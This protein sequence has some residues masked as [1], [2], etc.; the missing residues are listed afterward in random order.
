MPAT[1][2]YVKSQGLVELR[3][4]LMGTRGRATRGELA[5]QLNVDKST[6]SRWLTELE[7]HGVQVNED[8]QRRLWIDPEHFTDLS[9]TRD[10]SILLMLGLRLLQQFMDKPNS[11]IIELLDK[12]GTAFHK[13]RAPQV[14]QYVQDLARYQR[15]QLPDE[16][17]Y[18]DPEVVLSQISLAWLESRKVEIWYE[19]LHSQRPFTDTIHPYLI[20]PS[21]VGHSTYVIGFSEQ[22]QALRVYK[23]E[24]IKKRP[25]VLDLHFEPKEHIDVKRLLEGAWGIWFNAD[26]QPKKVVLRFSKEVR[27]RLYETRWHPSERKRDTEYGS[28]I[29]EGEIDEPQEMLPW[30][31]G[32]GADCEILEPQELREQHIREIQRQLSTYQPELPSYRPPDQPDN[33]LLNQLFG[34]F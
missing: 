3:R 14:G 27:K 33:D 24:R 17:P 23:I 11:H 16:R 12:L 10:E 18:P 20:E 9:L 29:W 19:P 7:S 13:S 30:I 26:E 22:A 25:L 15:E 5:K 21:A 4:R 34:G 32:W 31:R 2:G 1:K 28:V 6:I 8:E